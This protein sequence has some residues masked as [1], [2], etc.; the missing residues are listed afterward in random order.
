MNIN[1]NSSLDSYV[2]EIVAFK[3][4]NPERIM[5]VLIALVGILG[6]FYLFQY[7]AAWAVLDA[8]SDPIVEVR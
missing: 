4:K 8:G 2:K 3:S 6:T 1:I 5:I 7:D